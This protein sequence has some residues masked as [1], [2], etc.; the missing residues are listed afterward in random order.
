MGKLVFLT[1]H[2]HP[3]AVEL[4]RRAPGIELVEGPSLSEADAA[5]AFAAADALGVRIRNLCAADLD[6]APGLRVVA[7]HGVGTDNIDVAHCTMRA[8]PVLNTPDANKVAVAEHAMMLMLA[9]AK[10]LPQ[11]DKAVRE[12]NWRLRDGHDVRELAGRTLAII[13][14][15]RSGQEL[16]R[17][18]AAF[19]MRV[20]AWGRTLDAGALAA[21]GVEPAGSLTDALAEADIVSLHMPRPPGGGYLIGANEIALIKSGALFINC[22]RGGIVDEA[23]L[24]EAV[25]SGQIGGAGMDVFERE[26]PPLDHPLLHCPGVI[27][28]PHAAGNTREASRR[29]GIEMAENILAALDGRIPEDRLVNRAVVSQ[30]G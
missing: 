24:A 3:D 28:T 8:I 23:A 14:F 25:A 1:E 16:A 21:F 9:L 12:G 6:Q 29:M 22:A 15:G 19:D 11:S 7:K 26:P 13:G 5:A 18:A 17:R 2:V 30:L 4:L 10:R 27:V 20:L